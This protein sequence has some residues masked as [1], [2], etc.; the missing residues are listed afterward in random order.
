[1]FTGRTVCAGILVP[2]TRR[3]LKIFVKAGHHKQLLELLRRLR[4]RVKLAL[5][6]SGGNNII[7]CALRRRAGQ[8]RRRDL[9]KAKTFHLFAQERNN[10][11][12]KQDVIVN[13]L[14]SEIQKT[15]GKA[16]IFPRF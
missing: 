6:L 13:R 4:Q 1:K 16:Y 15:V 5:M 3:D 14:V 9:R 11:T 12:S 2:E 10:L 8:D 7:P